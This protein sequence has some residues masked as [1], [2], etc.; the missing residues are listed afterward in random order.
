MGFSFQQSAGVLE[1]TVRR[2]REEFGLPVGSSYT[3]MSDSELDEVVCSIVEITMDSG[4]CYIRGSLLSRGIIVQRQRVIDSMRRVD[5]VSQSI[6]RLTRVH[7][8]EYWV[9]GPNALW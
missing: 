2:R 4:L 9:P 1:R 8:R 5:P 6:R 3:N 7:R